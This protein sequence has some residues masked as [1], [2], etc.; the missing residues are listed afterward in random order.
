[1][2]KTPPKNE[3]NEKISIKPLMLRSSI[4]DSKYFIMMKA[5][6]HEKLRQNV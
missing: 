5:K 4:N 3:L 6:I 1:M 2:T